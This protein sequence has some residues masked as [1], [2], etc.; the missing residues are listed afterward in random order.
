MSQ[1]EQITILW[2]KD[3]KLFKNN[4]AN[5]NIN[6]RHVTNMKRLMKDGWDPLYP[7]ICDP[8]YFVFDGQHR[9]RAARQ[10]EL[11]VPYYIRTDLNSSNLVI[12]NNCQKRWTLDDY[13]KHYV[14]T[15]NENYIKFYDFCR[16]NQVTYSSGLNL[17]SGKTGGGSQLEPI[18]SGYFTITNK[19][20]KEAQI[21]TD[22]AKDIMSAVNISSEKFIRALV[23]VINNQEYNHERMMHK[24]RI[25]YGGI[26]NCRYKA[27]YIK[28]LQDVYNYTEPPKR[29]VI[30]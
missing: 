2:T 17:I 18:R 1:L 6:N 20:L 5:R 21:I 22:C 9:L 13:I 14:V 12:M 26:Q 23:I 16:F 29:R 4:P 30:F 27:L 7:L 24:L 25:Q 28:Q 19:E 10:L 11:S 3:Y 8:D 15:G